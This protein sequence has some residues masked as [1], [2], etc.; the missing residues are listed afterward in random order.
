MTTASRHGGG[1]LR[2]FRLFLLGATPPLVLFGAFLLPDLFGLLPEPIRK[3]PVE[4]SAVAILAAYL[5]ACALAR[6]KHG[7]AGGVDGLARALGCVDAV[8]GAMLER[9]LAVAFLGIAV[10][11]LL[12]WLPHYPFWP[13]CRDADTYAEMAQEWDCGLLPYRDIRAF[14]FPGHMYAHWIIGK[15]FGWGHTGIFYALDAAALLLLGSLLIVWSRRSLGFVLPGMAA[16]LIFL[17]YYLSIDFQIVAQRDWHASL[18]G[19]LGL[20]I[21]QV[22]PGR[23]SRLLSAVLAAV[24]FVIRPHIVLFFPALVAAATSGDATEAESPPACGTRAAVRRAI[25]PLLEWLG[26]FAGSVIVAFLPLELAG[27]LRD[28]IHGLTILRPGGPY[29]D[30]SSARSVQIVW[31]EMS[32][33]R[34]SALAC[35]LCAMVFGSRDRATKAM[36]G[37]WLLAQGAAMIYR[38]IHP[39]DH[40]Y[41]QTPLALVGAVGWAIPIAWIVQTVAA[42]PRRRCMRFPAVLA[43]LLIVYSAVPSISTANCSLAISIDAIRA[44]VRGGWPKVPPGAWSWYAYGRSRYSW[45]GYCQLLAYLRERT[46][47]D[48]IV[49]NVLRRP[50]FPSVNGAT[51]RRSPF[52]VESGVPWVYTVAE[53][54]DESFA[55]E[56][57]HEGKNSIVIWS[58][59]ETPQVPRLALERTIAVIQTRYAPEARFDSFE[60]WRRK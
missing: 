1:R 5:L 29:S 32:Q 22:W 56:L 45:G 35:A 17:A 23:R 24:G 19:I 13:W 18:C 2:L 9:W 51:G 6:F 10:L 25:M 28:F 46:D 31:D 44:A 55:R 30:A 38:P 7:R 8:C 52:R 36:A 34:N 53:D 49:A 26:M 50:P 14:N 20:L 60:V 37:T 33:P 47:Q 11:G 41:L 48:T 59:T 57:E 27:V 39:Q 40:G 42:E 12:T 16:Y 3:K 4:L 21:L 15:L 43:I 54:L 58:P